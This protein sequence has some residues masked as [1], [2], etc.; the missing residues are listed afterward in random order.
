MSRPLTKPNGE[1]NRCLRKRRERAAR[2]ANQ[3]M[4]IV[5]GA[6]VPKTGKPKKGVKK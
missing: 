6:P 4:M 1:P 3:P 2:N 5:R